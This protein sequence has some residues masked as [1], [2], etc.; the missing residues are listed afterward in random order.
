M[1]PRSLT[2]PALSLALTLA[3]CSQ[4]KS[5][6]LNA[7][8]NTTDPVSINA[9]SAPSKH[10]HTN[11]LAKEKSP[12]LLQHAHNPVDWFPWGEEAFAKA[13]KENKP[14]LL[15]IGYST[16]HWCHVME[17]ESFENEDVA[18]FLSEHFVS[19][20]LDREERPDV[21]KIYMTA[22]QAMGQGGG[23]PLNA[24]LTPDLKPFF[25]GT[26]FPPEPKFGR[27]SFMQ[28]LQRIA[29]LW[30]SQAQDIKDSAEQIHKQLAEATSTEPSPELVLSREAL[31]N[32]MRHF[33]R[34]HDPVH[35]GFGA[36]PK[37]PRPS[38]PAFLLRAGVRFADR[39]AVQAVLLT[40]DRM[41]AG[42]IYDHLGGG[43]ARYSVDEKWL[44]PH[45]EKMLYDN[46]Q[47]I[48]LYLDAFL[49]SGEARHADVARDIIKYILRDMTHPGGG[50][51]SAED[52]D[53]EGHEGKFYCWT[54][55]ELTK[56]LTPDELKLVIR[57][58]GITDEGN[59]EDHSHPEPL[60]K[61]NVLSIV[62]AALTPEEAPRLAAA[63]QKMFD[64]RAKRIRPHLDDKILA[65][66]NGLM[67]GAIA[68]AGAVLG[69]DT[70]RRAA[71]KNF[72]FLQEKL[73]NPSTRTLSHRWRDGHADA[74][75]FL[76]TYAFL[77]E[78][79]L[80]L[81]ESTLDPRHLEFSLALSET[82]L[83]KF[84]DP[85]HGG[86]F[87]SP[88]GTGDLILRVKEEYDGAEPSGNAVAALTLLKL[89]AI[90]D[91]KDLRKPAEDA[92]KLYAHRILA[93]PQVVPYLLLATDYNMEEPRRAVVAGDPASAPAQTLL[94]AIHT[95]YQPNKVVL[96]TTGPVEPFAKTL[97]AKDGPVV[98]VCTGTECKPPTSEITA[99]QAALR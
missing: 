18:K 85:Q 71:L 55:D 97:P 75:Q 58:F 19:I 51:Y 53:S 22:V 2:W 15:S 37:F 36:K 78:G 84:H 30:Q 92:V 96:G 57:R 34:G 43:F 81:Y 47:L 48:H 44:V 6:P 93:A 80:H 99:I 60:K 90:T 94:R 56:L 70:Y 59:F 67:L 46:A 3:A 63:R 52:A 7:G 8:T 32:A 39:D 1:P 62:D 69:D 82:M 9:T 76:D 65:S 72:A 4:Q 42:G 83:A 35:G 89:A 25:G 13:R 20:K 74:T 38:Q 66:W 45:F 27:P 29:L 31:T 26:Y 95:I 11:R 68:R 21:D 73:W 10:K 23:W 14:I 86:F 87:Q 77:A 91:R 17:R 24:F 61:Q 33:L 28:M 54:K 12:Y 41:A 16:C 49:V 50:F 98:Y 79:V 40:C 64:H 88:K 5:P